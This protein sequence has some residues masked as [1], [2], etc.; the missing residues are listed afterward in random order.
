[1]IT[2]SI[3]NWSTRDIAPSSRYEAWDQALNTSYGSWIASRPKAPD[4]SA[5]MRSAEIGVLS[6]HEC[7]CDPCSGTRKAWNI[8]QDDDFFAIQ[9]VHGGKEKI[10]FDG[11]DFRLKSGDIFIWDSTRPMTFDVIERLHKVSLVLPLAR[12]RQWLPNQWQ[13]LSGQLDG[14]STHGLLLASLISGIN[15]GTNSKDSVNDSAILEATV[16]ALVSGTSPNESSFSMKEEQMRRIE[17]FIS[18][19]LQDPNLSPTAIADGCKISLRYLHW[20]FGQSGHTP[21]KYILEKRLI[22]CRKDLLNPFMDTRSI[23]EI[24]YSSGFSNAA[25]FT[26]RYKE[27][28]SEAPSETRNSRFTETSLR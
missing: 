24:C 21:M 22:L 23:A 16:A 5:L 10:T 1:M 20:L 14:N 13:S 8:S 2:P 11:K 19:N 25:H 6:V 9:L 12:L 26:R 3:T 17:R 18:K 27:F 7:A 4:F 15:A 28:F